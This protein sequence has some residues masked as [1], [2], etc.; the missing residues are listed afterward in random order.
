MQQ[1]QTVWTTLDMRKKVIVVLATLAMFTAVLGLSRMASQPSMSLLYAGLEP[2]AAGEVVKAL[3]AQSAAFEVR[4]GAI[5]VDSAQRDGLRMTLASEGLPSNSAKGYELLDGLSGFG[6]TSQMFDAAYWRAKEGELAR[7][8]VSSPFV[9]SARVHI[10]QSVQQGLRR[11]ARPTGS[12]TLTANSGSVS[13]AQAKAFKYLVSSAVPG[14]SP[15]DVSIIDS[16]GG[17]ITAGD[18][19]E[20]AQSTVGNRS[21]ELKSNIQHLLEARVGL[22]NAVVELNLRRQQNENLFWKKPLTQTAVSQSPAMFRKTAAKV[23]IAVIVA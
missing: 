4:N 3:E 5:Y 10:A 16:R 21:E 15:E 13:A 11:R 6:T 1:I 18:D 8:I 17:L 12:V 22:G 2:S 23:L 19:A 7:T 9:Q 14:M 20:N